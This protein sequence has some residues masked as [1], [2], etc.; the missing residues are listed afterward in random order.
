MITITPLSMKSVDDAGN[1][2]FDGKFRTH[3]HGSYG[4]SIGDAPGLLGIAHRVTWEEF[5]NLTRSPCQKDVP[6]FAMEEDGTNRI[7]AWRIDMRGPQS[8]SALWAV[9]PEKPRVT[10]ESAFMVAVV[11]SLR[12]L[13]RP[14]IGKW[15]LPGQFLENRP[16]IV[17]FTSGSTWDQCPQLNASAFLFNK[18][19]RNDLSVGTYTSAEILDQKAKLSWFYEGALD[20]MTADAI[21]PFRR[22]QDCDE[23]RI[24]GVPQELVRRF[25]FGDS[26]GHNRMSVGGQGDLIPNEDLFKK[27]QSQA[28]SWGWG[29]NEAA[30]FLRS[31]NHERLLNSLVDGC[32][33]SLNKT[34]RAGE[35]LWTCLT[36]DLRVAEARDEQR[37]QDKKKEQE[38]TRSR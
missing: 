18:A 31:L 26:V 27:W 35:N 13:N 2:F 28:K 7:A 29:Q 12:C 20:Y 22:V 9:A 37:N 16:V 6:N 30:A 25:F 34:I 10:I 32:S 23:M 15:A 4:H 17:L 33:N 3:R 5:Q 11:E 36:A 24:Q 19:V 38:Q 1:E 14:T 8:L 21:G